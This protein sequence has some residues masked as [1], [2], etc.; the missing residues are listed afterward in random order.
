MV[1]MFSS[2][3][4]IWCNINSEFEFPTTY[5]HRFTEYHEMI[6]TSIMT[7]ELEGTHRIR[8]HAILLYPNFN[9]NL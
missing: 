9:P 7:A 2:S 6:A 8:T 3:Q 4:L 1:K 5:D